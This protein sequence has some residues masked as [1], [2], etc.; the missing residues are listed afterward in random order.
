MTKIIDL[1]LKKTYMNDYKTDG[2]RNYSLQ[3]KI[4]KFNIPI[5]II[6]ICNKK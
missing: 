5:Y 6:G 1:Y 4:I 2:V 3:V